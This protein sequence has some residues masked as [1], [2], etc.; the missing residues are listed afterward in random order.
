MLASLYV[1]YE[2]HMVPSWRKSGGREGRPSHCGKWQ[3]DGIDKVN[4]DVMCDIVRLRD[5]RDG[6]PATWHAQGAKYHAGLGTR[7]EQPRRAESRRQIS[8]V[9][10]PSCNGVSALYMKDITADAMRLQR[11]KDGVLSF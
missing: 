9:P 10:M 3:F 4:R 1:S 2:I 7:H 11:E 5:K 6:L 8:A